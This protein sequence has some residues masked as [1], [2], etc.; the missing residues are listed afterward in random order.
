MV[1]GRISR[2]SIGTALAALPM[3][4]AAQSFDFTPDTT[5]IL[6]DPAFLPLTGQIYGVTDYTYT[7]V[8]GTSRDFTGAAQFNAREWSDEIRQ[9]LAYGITDDL[10]V[11]ANIA[12]DPFEEHKRELVDGGSV[13]HKDS[14]FADPSFNVTW[15]AFDQGV[16][17]VNLDL[18]GSYSPDWITA[19]TATSSDDGTIARGGQAGTVGVALSHVTRS[20]TI[21]GSFAADLFGRSKVENP[22]NEAVTETGSHTD[23]TLALNT[24]T[25]FTDRL[26]L[27]AGL[28][29]VWNANAVVFNSGSDMAHLNEPE[30]GNNLRVALNYHLVPNTVVAS[31]T[32]GHDFQENIRNIFPTPEAAN[33]SLRTRDA[34]LY[35]AKLDYVFP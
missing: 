24:Q 26:S 7:D 11:G 18:F 3:A 32:Y 25:R 15:R 20:F 8:H 22:T 5:R 17:P 23:F 6:S 9:T 19:K 35:G 13:I 33:D 14:G 4:A 29:H 2:L 30:N 34:N 28:A 12:Y 31:L 1:K 21:Y 27:N 10:T 16:Q